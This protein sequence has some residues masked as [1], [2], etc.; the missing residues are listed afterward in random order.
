VRSTHTHLKIGTLSNQ[1]E[2]LLYNFA[3]SNPNVPK[4]GLV[5]L[6]AAPNLRD[7]LNRTFKYE[8]ALDL[9]F[10]LNRF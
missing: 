9:L 3:F 8:S 7:V 1:P 6:I 10:V 4:V 5:N 2:L